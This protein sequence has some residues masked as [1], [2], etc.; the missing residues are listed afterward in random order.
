[1]FLLVAFIL[2]MASPAKFDRVLLEPCP[3][4]AAPYCGGASPALATTPLS[5]LEA[6]LALAL[7]F[8]CQISTPIIA[9]DLDNPTRGRLAATYAIALGIAT[10]LYMAMYMAVGI[11]GYLTFGGDVKP[12]LLNSY[13]TSPSNPLVSAARLGIAFV[14]IFSYPIMT[15]A[16]RASI[17]TI[18]TTV[19]TM[20]GFG[21]S[22]A[23]PIGVP[24]SGGCA[25]LFISE[26]RPI[27]LS[28][29]F[30]VATLIVGLTVEDLGI[31]VD[32]G[33]AT[34][35]MIVAFIAPSLAFTLTTLK[36]RRGKCSAAI[37]ASILIAELGFVMMCIGIGMKL[38]GGGDDDVGTTL[39]LEDFDA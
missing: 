10:A 4:T 22:L 9:S 24:P 38:L 19:A 32:L 8:A 23:P 6:T 20:C 17:G 35:A 5:M 11:A 28:A 16:A 37:V 36:A 1:M 15:F 12:N 30:V 14:C 33:G 31:I 26:Y 2:A 3:S 13:P 29:L 7:A 18:I 39:R 21:G 25:A 27:V 34:G